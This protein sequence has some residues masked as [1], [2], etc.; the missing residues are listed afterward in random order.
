MLDQLMAPLDFEMAGLV[1]AHL[2]EKGV[3]C[4]LGTG[5]VSFAE[6]GERVIVTTS[7][8]KHYESDLV[9]LSIGIKPENRLAR[10]AGLEIGQRTQLR[11]EILLPACQQ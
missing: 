1:Q 6:K 10:D 4:I 11:S 7:D 9:I 5:V 3:R 8:G 2:K